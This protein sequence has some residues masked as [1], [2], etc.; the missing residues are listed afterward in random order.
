[1]KIANATEGTTKIIM[2]DAAV[3]IADIGG[4]TISLS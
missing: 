1:M 2:R 4:T 3:A